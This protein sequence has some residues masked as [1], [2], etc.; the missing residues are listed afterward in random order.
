MDRRILGTVFLSV[1]QLASVSHDG[2][3][4]VGNPAESHLGLEIVIVI[5][6][7]GEGH[8]VLVLDLIA[9]SGIGSS[10]RCLFVDDEI[11]GYVFVLELLID[12]FRLTGG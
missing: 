11:Y 12:A 6:K 8:A 1:D 10:T 9:V 2:T 5:Q 3:P 7:H 4:G